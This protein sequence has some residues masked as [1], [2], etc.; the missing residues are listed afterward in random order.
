VPGSLRLDDF[1]DDS[2]SL[3]NRD[4]LA[5]STEMFV[6]DILEPSDAS[7]PLMGGVLRAREALRPWEVLVEPSPEIVKTR[8]L[9]HAQC[10]V[11][12]QRDGRLEDTLAYTGVSILL[13][14][15]E[16]EIPHPKSAERCVS[17]AVSLARRRLYALV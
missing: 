1:H 17:A 15:D 10:S 3:Q 8:S 4:H 12:F 13:A 5:S 14:N 9:G 2:L 16:T 6:G 7:R 11:P